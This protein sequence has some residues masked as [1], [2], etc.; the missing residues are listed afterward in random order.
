VDLIDRARAAVPTETQ[1]MVMR[2]DEQA[3]AESERRQLIEDAVRL[4]IEQLQLMPGFRFS[5]DR[6]TREFA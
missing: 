5:C 2:G 1:V 3:F 6:G 4:F